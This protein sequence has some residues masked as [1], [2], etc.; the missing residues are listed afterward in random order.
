M[1]FG[2]LDVVVLIFHC[3]AMEHWLSTSNGG[4]VDLAGSLR[5]GDSRLAV[6]TKALIEQNYEAIP[7][8]C[9]NRNRVNLRFKHLFSFSFY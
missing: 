4:S 5:L 6:G 8:I 1:K 3:N 7:P 2:I 9:R